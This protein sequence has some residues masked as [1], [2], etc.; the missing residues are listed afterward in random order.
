LRKERHFLRGIGIDGE[1]S[2]GTKRNFEVKHLSRRGEEI[3]RESLSS[4]ERK[5]IEDQ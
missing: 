4:G 2:Q 3:N 5:E 1:R